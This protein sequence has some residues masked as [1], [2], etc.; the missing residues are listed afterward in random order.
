MLCHELH[1]HWMKDERV[2][3][4]KNLLRRVDRDEG[5]NVVGGVE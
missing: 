3:L 5:S 1:T 2:R 4:V